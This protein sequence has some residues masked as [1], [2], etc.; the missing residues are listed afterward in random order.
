MNTKLF[1]LSAA[2]ALIVVAIGCTAAPAPASP[3]QAP[4]SA[5][6][7]APEKNVCP[8]AGDTDT[9]TFINLKHA[10]EEAA[11]T[12]NIDIIKSIYFDNATIRNVELGTSWSPVVDSY[13]ESFKEADFIKIETTDFQVL[14]NTGNRAW[15][16][17]HDS[18]VLVDVNTNERIEWQDGIT[19]LIFEKNSS[20]CWLI[21]HFSISASSEPFPIDPESSTALQKPLVPAPLPSDQLLAKI[22]VGAE[23]FRLAI[24][25][26]AVWVTDQPDAAV[27]RIDP[28]TNQVVATISLSGSPK[29]LVVGEGAVW[30]A[31]QGGLSRIDPDTN[32]VVTTIDVGR[33]LNPAVGAGSVWVTSTSGVVSRI[34]P[35]TNQVIASITVGGIPSQIAIANNAV[36]VANREST[37]ISRID[38]ETNQVA[39]SIDVGFSTLAL[40]ADQDS[41]W[42]AGY[43]DST[44]L[45]I[46][47]Q[48]N[49][50]VA[51]I[52]VGVSPWGI[53]ADENGVWVTSNSN[54]TLSRIDPPTNQVVAAYEVGLGPLGV[55][56]GDG[57]LWVVTSFDHTVWRIK[58]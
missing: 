21:S 26:G 47:P 39:A 3:T 49:Q 20:G 37:S 52:P 53:A 13:Q 25:E 1:K 12:K 48:T 9:Q 55:G 35:E 40:A 36:W 8:Y 28:Q 15:V 30:V 16:V 41:V 51:R 7:S 17:T 10:E 34:D 5:P 22:S 45:R 44:L 6:T 19:H 58:P 57:D 32:Q 11:R 4:T 38:P 14:K 24:G 46:D 50:I 54:K 2:F 56:I 31:N 27:Y 29:G 42:V 43:S 23:P 33:G 18:G